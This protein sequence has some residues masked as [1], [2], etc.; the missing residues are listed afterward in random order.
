MNEAAGRTDDAIAQWR[1]LVKL[2][3]YSEE[4]HGE[5]GK[6]LLR[7]GRFTE[8]TRFLEEARGSI[9]GDQDRKRMGMGALPI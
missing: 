5:L 6:S 7:A 2:R 3:P 4:T 1:Q 9:Q 8:A